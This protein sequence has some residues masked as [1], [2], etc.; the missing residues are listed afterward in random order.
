MGINTTGLVIGGIIAAATAGGAVYAI[1]KKKKP[2]MTPRFLGKTKIALPPRVV[3]EKYNF[4]NYTYG[5]RENPHYYLDR[6]EMSNWDIASDFGLSGI[7]K[8]KPKGRDN[9]IVGSVPQLPDLTF[10]FRNNPRTID[11]RA[12]GVN[13]YCDPK[14]FWPTVIKFRPRWYMARMYDR[15]IGVGDAQ[16]GYG[17]QNKRWRITGLDTIT[18]GAIRNFRENV[19]DEYNDQ[20]FGYYTYA[21]RD[22]IFYNGIKRI[23]NYGSIQTQDGLAHPYFHLPYYYM[24]SDYAHKYFK[25]IGEYQSKMTSM[26]MNYDSGY[27]YVANLKFVH[28]ML[29]MAFPK[30]DFYDWCVISNGQGIDAYRQPIGQNDCLHSY[31]CTMCAKQRTLTVADIFKWIFDVA[32]FIYNI[33]SGSIMSSASSSQEAL[34]SS[35]KIQESANGSA[36][37]QGLKMVEFVL[38]NNRLPTLEKY[39]WSVP[40]DQLSIMDL[41]PSVCEPETGNPCI[42]IAKQSESAPTIKVATVQPI[43]HLWR[44]T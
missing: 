16:V 18:P 41:I 2:V 15:V 30:M 17:G 36:F 43:S 21:D 44:K 3:L 9:E 22:V 4:A 25:K 39:F 6:R 42:Q 23:M 13:F 20:T 40:V 28:T 29:L 38:N 24:D 10:S 31:F 19:S 33:C 11:E 14:D 5:Q 35:A 12:G 34:A 26:E 27:P 1:T 32:Q 37:L 7:S 8:R